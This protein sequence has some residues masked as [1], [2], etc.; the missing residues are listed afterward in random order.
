MFLIAYATV[1]LLAAI[2][3]ALTLWHGVAPGT[4]ARRLYR[5]FAYVGAAILA[6][7]AFDLALRISLENYW[8][9]EL[10]QQSRYW[11]E[12]GLRSEIFL[13]I[14]LVGGLFVA[15]NLHLAFR[16]IPFA[17]PS[18]PWIA[19][20]I[21]SGVVASGAVNDWTGLA[22]FLGASPTGVKSIRC[23]TRT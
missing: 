1:V 22:A 23:F 20:F 13:A 2:P 3:L 12:L 21:A 15:I 14:F 17:P 6:V 7:V 9:T 5:N 10:G 18:A 16:P 8:F 11:F 4:L 19:G